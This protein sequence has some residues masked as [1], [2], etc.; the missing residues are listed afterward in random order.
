MAV[1]YRQC[2]SFSHFAI[3][4]IRSAEFV[5]IENQGLRGWRRVQDWDLSTPT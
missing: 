5:Q 2:D 4:P 1:H 3:L